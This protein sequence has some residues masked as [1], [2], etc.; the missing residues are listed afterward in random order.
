MPLRATATARFTMLTTTIASM[1]VRESP[2]PRSTAIAPKRIAVAGTSIDIT[3]R[4][5]RKSTAASPESPMSRMSGS[6]RSMSA[7]PMITPT[8]IARTIVW[9]TAARAVARRPLP[10]ERLT[11]AVAPTSRAMIEIPTNHPI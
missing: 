10:I 4:K 8:M 3:R 5:M 2:A 11:S 1:G 7:A 9:P 6:R